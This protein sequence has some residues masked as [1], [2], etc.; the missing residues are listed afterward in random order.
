MP[1][2]SSRILVSGLEAEELLG[3]YKGRHRTS[4]RLVGVEAVEREIDANVSR[5][6]YRKLGHDDRFVSDHGRALR[7]PFLDIRF[8]TSVSGQYLIRLV[9]RLPFAE[10]ICDLSFPD[11]VADKFLQRSA[12]ERISPPTFCRWATKARHAI[13]FTKETCSGA[14]TGGASLFPSSLRITCCDIVRNTLTS[15]GYVKN[16][17]HDEIRDVRLLRVLGDGQPCKR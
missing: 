3:G 1:L 10:C 13:R 9:T 11:G 17:L 14:E 16:S 8:W 4:L 2:S 12:A 5:S 7:H 6:W 15:N